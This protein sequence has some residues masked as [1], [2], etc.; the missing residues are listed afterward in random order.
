MIIAHFALNF[1]VGLAGPGGLGLAPAVPLMA[2][3]GG[4]AVLASLLLWTLARRPSAA[5]PPAAPAPV[6]AEPRA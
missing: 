6:T 1:S 5:R 2:I 4:F 3:F